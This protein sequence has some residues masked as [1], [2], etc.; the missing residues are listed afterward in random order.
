M[1][2]WKKKTWSLAFLRE[3]AQLAEELMHPDDKRVPMLNF[4]KYLGIV[5]TDVKWTRRNALPRL[6]IPGENLTAEYLA[7]V[8]YEWDEDGWTTP[9]E[10]VELCLAPEVAGHE[11]DVIIKALARLGKEPDDA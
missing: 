5:P 8:A 2:D 6:G 3:Q 10:F 11:R 1:E 4:L 9:T 7:E